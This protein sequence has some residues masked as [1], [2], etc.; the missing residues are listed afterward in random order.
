MKEKIKPTLNNKQ[1]IIKA[2]L[3][4]W[5]NHSAKRYGIIAKHKYKKLR[6]L[7]RNNINVLS[8]ILSEDNGLSDEQKSYLFSLANWSGSCV[9]SRNLE[10]WEFH[11]ELRARRELLPHDINITLDWYSDTHG[12]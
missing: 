8:D 11:T 3:S 6:G 1:K 4:H 9:K 12:W 5:K 7:M 10:L 2:F